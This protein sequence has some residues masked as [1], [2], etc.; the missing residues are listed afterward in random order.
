MVVVLYLAVVGLMRLAFAGF[1]TDH[2]AGL[3]LAFAAALLL[4]VPAR[5]TTPCGG[6]A[7]R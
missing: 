2:V 6:G 5:R 1:G 4:G 7:F 3:F